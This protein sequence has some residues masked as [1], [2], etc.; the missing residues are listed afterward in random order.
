MV[1]FEN[2][3]DFCMVIIAVITL[4]YTFMRKDK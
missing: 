3:F 4:V 1:T 2:L